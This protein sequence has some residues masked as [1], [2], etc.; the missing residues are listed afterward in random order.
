MEFTYRAPGLPASSRRAA[1]AAASAPLPP[2]DPQRVLAH[3]FRLDGAES[4][5]QALRFARLDLQQAREVVKAAVGRM[6]SSGAAEPPVLHDLLGEAR[7]SVRIRT[8]K[9]L[10]RSLQVFELTQP[11]V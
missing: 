2:P 6:L 9:R 7:T 5:A 10:N 3:L 8:L 1:S 11:G 4:M